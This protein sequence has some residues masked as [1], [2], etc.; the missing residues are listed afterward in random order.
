VTFTIL[1]PTGGGAPRTGFGTRVRVQSTNPFNIGDNVIAILNEIGVSTNIIALARA[2]VGGS[3][4]LCDLTWG[5]NDIDATPAPLPLAGPIGYAS[6]T[7][8]LL[9]DVTFSYYDVTNALIDGPQLFS[10]AFTNDP[11]TQPGHLLLTKL[12]DR[13]DILQNTIIETLQP[14][15]LTASTVHAGLTG[16]GAIVMEFGNNAAKV[17]ITARGHNVGIQAGNPVRLFNAGWVSSMTIDGTAEDTRLDRDVTFVDM[18]PFGR[19]LGYS[20]ADGVTATITEVS[21]N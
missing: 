11:W 16:S 14:T 3:S 9:C 12:L 20:L 18:R 4:R 10:A 6:A 5:W 21:V 19:T 8:D 2:N 17:A 7:V 1:F 13:L 15:N